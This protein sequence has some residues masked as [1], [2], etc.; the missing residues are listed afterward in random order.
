MRNKVI[1]VLLTVVLLGNLVAC[2]GYSV[3]NV[4]VHQPDQYPSYASSE[5][6]AVAVDS[7]AS[8]KKSGEIFSGVDMNKSGYL[9][10]NCII[11][12]DGEEPYKVTKSDLYLIDKNGVRL[13][14]TTADEMIQSVGTSHAKWF[15]ISGFLGMFSADR[16]KKKFHE[17]L[18][19]KEFK[20]TTIPS[21]VTNFGFLYFQ[22]QVHSP[23]FAKGYKLVV[24]ND[25]SGTPIQ[26]EIK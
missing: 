12:N 13:L 17:D 8:P 25:P 26:V 5:T 15:F 21:G 11:R 6:L 4:V 14:P 19:N 1:S 23:E 9:V 2:A 20:D 16:A 3:K 22:H 24:T 10:V 18:R 7:L